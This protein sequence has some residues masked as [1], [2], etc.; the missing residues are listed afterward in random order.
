MLAQVASL[1]SGIRLLGFAQIPRLSRARVAKLAVT[2]G[3]AASACSATIVKAAEPG[4]WSSFQNSGIPVTTASLPTKWSPESVAW[5]TKLTGYGQSTVVVHE[6]T[7]YVTTTEGEN[8]EKY[9]LE[10]L[11]LE[12]GQKKWTVSFENPS[13]EKNSTYVSRAAPTPV[14]DAQACYLYFEGGVIAAVAHSG[15]TIWQRD[16]VEQYGAIKARHGIA[17][18]LEQDDTSLFV[19]VERMEE[20]YLLAV[21]KATGKNKWKVPGLGST[22]WSTPR[23][24]S[25]AG[26][27]QLVCSSSG[28]IA[29]FDP[30]TGEQLWDF[31]GV[32]N[33]TSCSPMP[34]GD[35]KF[36]IGASNGRGEENAAKGA[37]YNGVVEITK[38]ADGWTAKY[39][40]HATRA[41][42][43]FGSPVVHDGSAYFVDRGGVL[44]V[45]DLTTGK[46][47][48][49]KRVDC[50]GIWATPLVANNKLYLFG[51]KGATTV[52]DLATGEE[53]ATN[54]LWKVEPKSD[55]AEDGRPSSGSVLY[56][57]T[58]A[59]PYLILRRGDVVY[60]IK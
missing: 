40:W 34:V 26:T 25:V 10:A 29:G 36:L 11:S 56:A 43:S 22:T 39:A 44:Y 32:A 60:A 8:K 7:L 46:E 24:M 58:V 16:L 41:T 35:G 28:K 38:S 48:R 4:S 5:K 27:K 49:P 42:S 21:D 59:P 20:P 54:S 3:L 57:G 33:N 12:S 50:G 9:H 14:V 18:S 37:A 2:V 30:Q 31:D 17:S 13:P 23:L 53:I 6:G 51:Q 45:N 52:I 47:S 55:S 1:R 19:W 15:E